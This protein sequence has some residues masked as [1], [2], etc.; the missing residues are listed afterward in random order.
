MKPIGLLLAAGRGHR[1]GGNKQF[2]P[3]QTQTG[4]KPL[5]AAAFDTIAAAC[6]KMF[7]VLGDRADEVAEALNKGS[8]LFSQAENSSAPFVIVDPDAPMF[9]S[10][11][12]G[13]RAA[14]AANPAAS[15]L[16]QLGDHPSLQPSTLEKILA[17]AVVHPDIAIIPTFDNKGGHPILI[18]PQIAALI[19]SMD[20]VN[21]L[22]QFWLEKPSYCLRLPV[23]DGGVIHDIDHL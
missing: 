11:Q 14:L 7:V 21:G 10:I 23:A 18:P 12:A 20:C 16:L 3:V 15:I 6:E 8:E 5:V 22:R 17:L 1:M 4:E 13:L 9:H 19:L 2:H